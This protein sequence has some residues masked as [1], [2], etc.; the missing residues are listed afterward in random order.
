MLEALHDVDDEARRAVEALQAALGLSI[1]PTSLSPW[2]RNDGGNWHWQ[3]QISRLDISGVE[4]GPKE[5]AALATLLSPRLNPDGTYSFP[6]PL[7]TL[8]IH[9]VWLGPEAAAEIV[10]II[11]PRDEAAG[12]CLARNTTLLELDLQGL[13]LVAGLHALFAS[14][15]H[16]VCSPNNPSLR[17]GDRRSS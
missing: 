10:A 15:T 5:A 7:E 8:S 3:D 12:A 6:E 1:D 16:S 4:I 17:P 14:S 11:K 2:R 13:S 9:G